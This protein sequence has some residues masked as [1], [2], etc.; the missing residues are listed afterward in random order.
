MATTI[1]A[2]QATGELVCGT[3]NIAEAL[4]WS[5]RAPRSITL[6]YRIQSG[7]WA[8]TGSE[9]SPLSSNIRQDV[10]A[11]GEYVV[12]IRSGQARNLHRTTLLIE[13]DAAGSVGYSVE[14]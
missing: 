13:M 6:D 4:T 9:G 1:S 12:Q 2:N 8:F 7:G 11:N 14:W 5:G 10:D 3:A